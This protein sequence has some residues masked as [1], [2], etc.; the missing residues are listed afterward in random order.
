MGDLHRSGLSARTALRTVAAIAVATIRRKR[1]IAILPAAPGQAANTTCLAHPAIT[2][3]RSGFDR[4]RLIALGVADPDGTTV[5]TLA[6]IAAI[7]AM[8]AIAT[9]ST[10]HGGQI[11]AAVMLAASIAA[12][13]P[14]TPTAR[15]AAIPAV[16]PLAIDFNRGNQGKIGAFQGKPP[17]FARLAIAATAAGSAITAAGATG[18]RLATTKQA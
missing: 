3:I 11:A 8:P 2:A 18:G 1:A 17:G 6:T 9:M 15:V 10:G 13:P 4:Q 14:I 7:A 16:P 5:G 12:I